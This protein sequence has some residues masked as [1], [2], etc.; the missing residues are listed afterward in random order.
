VEADERTP[1]QVAADIA[2]LHELRGTNGHLN[3]VA[4]GIEAHLDNLSEWADEP[5]EVA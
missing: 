3:G 1:E 2:W 4:G 5:A